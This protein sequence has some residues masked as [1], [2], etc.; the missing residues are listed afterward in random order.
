MGGITF[1][2]I[3]PTNTTS[4]SITIR[5]TSPTSILTTNKR[6]TDLH[7]CIYSRLWLFQI[8]TAA[9]GTEPESICSFRSSLSFRVQQKIVPLS[10]SVERYLD[11]VL[12]NFS[13]NSDFYQKKGNICHKYI[14]TETEITQPTDRLHS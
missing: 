10:V 5:T 14:S 9:S 13:L 11:H 4:S 2:N 3:P 8:K 6:S 7:P 12:N 1:A